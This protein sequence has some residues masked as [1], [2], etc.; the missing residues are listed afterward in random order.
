MTAK[1]S[2][3]ISGI[4]FILL[5]SFH[6]A[7]CAPPE[8]QPPRLTKFIGVDISGSFVH[9]GA[10]DNSLGFLANYIY[11]HVN[12]IG[13]FEK[14]NYMFVSSIGGMEYA[15][16]KT[17][18][19]IHLFQNRSVEEIEAYLHELYP[20]SHLEPI[21]DFNA[22][23]EHVART[24]ENHNLV[25]RPVSVV[26]ISDG[27]PDYFVDGERHLRRFEDID[28]SPLERL[29]RNIAIRVLYTDPVDG[30]AWQTEVPRRRVRIWTQ[31]ADVMETWN[32]PKIYIPNKPVEEQVLWQEWTMSNVNYNVRAR[33]VD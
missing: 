3:K 7:G 1:L 31:D 33:R 21:T 12:G 18:Y 14:P 19:P 17:F 13:D 23:F 11:A 22:F 29:S 9:S 16:T 24:I 32:D 2:D 20:S 5:L 6:F 30:R 8:D 26:L 15:E 28:V 4:F 10:Y 27:I 25:L